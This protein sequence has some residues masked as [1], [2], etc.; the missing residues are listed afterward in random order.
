M[1]SSV[2]K[3]EPRRKKNKP[4]LFRTLFLLVL[5]GVAAFVVLAIR[6]YKLQI[7]DH[8]YYE[9]QALLNQL[10]ETT[11][12]ASR[13]S[14][15]DTNGKILA[16]SA[17]VENVFI[18][19]FE[20]ERDEQDIEI[21]SLGL[22]DILGVERASIVDMAA[23]TKSQ[24]QI[25]KYGVENEE[26]RQVRDFISEYSLKGIYLEPAVKRYYPNNTLASQVLGFVGM[27]NNGLD[28]VE[29]QFDDQLTG[30]DGRKIRLRNA[31][32]A[33]LMLPEYDDYFE[34]QDGN[35]IVLTIDSSI[36]YYVE[37]HLAQAIIDYDVQNGATC[38]AM[39][40]KTGA[41]LAMANYPNYDPN[42]FLKLSD[43]D[44]ESL[45]SIANADEYSEAL[46]DAQLR[47]WRNRAL[48]DT[49][50]PGSVFKLI[51]LSIA[52]EENVTYPDDIFYCDGEM[53]IQGREP[54]D[55]LHC[56]NLYGHGA[57]TLRD[58]MRNS[59]NI[60]SAT[61]SLRIGARTYY[62][63]I[64]AF[65]LFDRTGLDNSAEG[66]SLWWDE[67]VFLNR[68]NQSQLAA[69]SFGQTFKVTPIQ[70]I[71][72]AAAAI[73][74][75]YLMKPYIVKQ[76]T[77]NDGSII[78][79]IEPTVLRQV[80]SEE[81]SSTVRSILEDVVNTGTGTNARVRGYRVGGKTGTSENVE[82]LTDEQYSESMAK[83]YIVSFIGFAPADDP[84]III[85]LILD[86]PSNETGLYISGGAMAAPVVGNMLA[87]ILPL[88]LGVRPQYTE[89]DMDE[90]NVYIPRVVGKSVEEAQEALIDLGLEFRVIGNSMSVTSQ[91]P[92]PN[93]YVASGTTVIL[94]ADEDTP[95]EEVTVPSLSGMPYSEAK[96]TLESSGLFIRTTGASRLNSRTEVSV[97][98]IPAGEKTIYGSVIE[99]TL[100]NKD[101]VER[102]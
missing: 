100:I 53:E 18:S 74:G 19:P 69:A 17:A 55:P 90:I 82:Q 62:K 97:Q 73:N 4:L 54:D 51:T 98:S 79:S 42:D 59:C 58:A 44:M 6:L 12:T 14:I 52:L 65:G 47:Q 8:D 101:A 78:D 60:M 89:E 96:R 40:A 46:Y 50:E 71:T 13:G 15:Y 45:S 85:L 35:N 34:A 81:T 29:Q 5:C 7:I 70:M 67:S 22:S 27:D 23:N 86:K 49:Y 10:G 102:N 39:H 94:Y 72:A 37:K 3:V 56:W 95:K 28:G 75:G 26:A 33:D 93:A 61:L 41:I 25:V 84:E 31:R 9:S 43:K 2:V 32:G 38:I 99:V 16:M 11:I 77:D 20:I 48:A 66:R 92:M 24:Y 68:Y 76:I 36:Q 63:Y 64:E 83:D 57:Q 91:L 88:C 87:D 80:I 1:A 21:I 30:V